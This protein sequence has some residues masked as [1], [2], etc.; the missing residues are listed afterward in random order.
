MA[1]S[2]RSPRRRA[3]RP[4]RRGGIAGAGSAT[5]MATAA[6]TWSSSL[7]GVLEPF[8][9]SPGL[10]RRTGARPGSHY[11]V[12][13]STARS[14]RLVWAMLELLEPLAERCPRRQLLHPLRADR[15]ARTQDLPPV[16]V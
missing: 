13:E 10:P 4:S 8:R 16:V 15:A 12:M 14:W 9:L 3:L 1:L 2:G 7:D 5:S 11:D 6:W